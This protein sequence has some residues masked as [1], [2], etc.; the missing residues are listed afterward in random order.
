[1]GSGGGFPGLIIAIATNRHVHLIESDQRK[2]AFLREA[3]R[4]TA[5][6]VT[7]HASRI[8]AA[9]LP[10]VP[11]VT[12]RALAPLTTLLDWATHHLTSNGVC[13]FPKRRTAEEE[14]TTAAERWHM[15]IERFPSPTDPAATILRLS[16]IAR[17]GPSDPV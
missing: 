1:M 3:A 4:A 11:L 10:P 5:A 7:V 8:E 9:P 2:A 12:A 13:V 6:P 16:E 15:R 17:A 14:L